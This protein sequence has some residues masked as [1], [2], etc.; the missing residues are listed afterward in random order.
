M[1]NLS[2][3]LGKF[4]DQWKLANACPVYKSDDS[5]LSKNYRPISLLCVVSKFLE[6]CVFN[7][8]YTLISPQLYHLQHGFLRGRSTVTQLL[9]V[10]HEAIEAQA[11]G[12]EID[13][14]YLDF[15]KTFDKVPHCALLN[16]LSRFG[17]SGQLINW[18][19]SYLSD[20]YQRVALQGTY[21]DWLQ[22]LSGVPQG[23]IL[24]PLLFLVY[25]DDIPQCIKHDSKVAIFA[26]DSKLF[27]I[28]E[29]P[30]DKLSLQDLT[31]PSIW[32]DTWKMCL[33]IP[34]CKA[35]NISRK[36]IPTKR[37]Y[38]LNG[39]PLATV[40]E[41]YDLCITV[42]N[43]LQ[44]SQHIKLISSKA[45][46]TLGLIRRVCRDINDPDIKKLLYCSIVRPQLE[47]ACELWSPYTSK[48]KLLLET[49]QRRA[50][51]LI[52]NYAREISYRDLLLKLSLLP[53]EYRRE[54][55][56]MVLITLEQAI[57][58]WVTKTFSVKL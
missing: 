3:S 32:S 24:G 39:S 25:I 18:F 35:L 38:H 26:D 41:I 12:K 7:H 13:I 30:S 4:P 20:R 27:K 47:Y 22:V 45:N 8:C 6:R 53:L 29:K 50:T 5:T 33:S 54:M 37:E 2:L 14:A 46:R 34:K 56:D 28:I 52:L 15:A 51:K 42:T 48:D 11:K 57:L 21:S 10:Y 1:F 43:T 36:K 31:Q 9:Q 16:K 23:S 44:W 40:S 58:I 17:I 19:Q 49:V 55:K